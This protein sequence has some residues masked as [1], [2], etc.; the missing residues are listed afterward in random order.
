MSGYSSRREAEQVI[1]ASVITNGLDPKDYYMGWVYHD[2]VT[3]RGRGYGYGIASDYNT[4]M[5]VLDR[6][7]R[8]EARRRM[9]RERHDED[10]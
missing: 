10:G 3:E 6:W 8:L 2:L 9:E 1:R 5:S 7:T 4:F